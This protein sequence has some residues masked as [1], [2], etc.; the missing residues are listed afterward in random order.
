MQSSSKI[1]HIMLWIAQVVL[2]ATLIWAGV[3]KLFQPVDAV[4]TMWPWAGEVPV[5][6]LKFTGIVDV[7]GA[8][9]LILP[10]LLRIRPVLTPLAA[11]ALVVLMLCAGIFHVLRGEASV[12][13]V[14]I[15]FALIAA[16]IA[17]GRWKKVPVPSKQN[18]HEKHAAA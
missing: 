15:I 2:A 10:A 8:L 12:I 17:W 3:M 13:G 11:A 16:F 14:N 4:A 6:L 1:L 9:G 5:A 7:L 18:C